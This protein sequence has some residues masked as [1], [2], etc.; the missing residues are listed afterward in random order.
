MWTTPASAAGSKSLAEWTRRRNY[1]ISVYQCLYKSR[2][3]W[4]ATLSGPAGAIVLDK[5]I[6][7]YDPYLAWQR[8]APRIFSMGPGSRT[9]VG[10]HKLTPGDYVF[11]FECVGSNP[12]A[13][14][15]ESDGPGLNCRLDGISLRRFPWDNLYQQMQRYLDEEQRLF[16]DMA[17]RAKREVASLDAAIVRFRKDV[18]QYPAGPADLLVRPARLQTAGGAWPY[19]AE[20]PTDPWGQDY[21]YEQPGKFNPGE[22]DIYSVH[23]D[24]R[25]PAGWI[26]NW[27]SPSASRT[28]WK[29]SSSPSCGGPRV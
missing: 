10:I 14:A 8:T 15:E 13:R 21:R 17:A 12:L 4:K 9:K 23:G 5:A 7:F 28:R 11:R 18:G 29:A 27:P 19:L 16:A 26:G 1:S 3:V 20:I 22:F 2:G 25:N 24:S 6:D